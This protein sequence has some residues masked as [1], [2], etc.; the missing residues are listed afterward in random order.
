MA[1]PLNHLVDFLETVFQ[2]HR[3]PPGERGGVFHPAEKSV[4][5]L[6]LA[7]EAEPGLAEWLFRENIDAL[8]C[9]RPWQ[10]DPAALP[11]GVGVLFHHLPF[12]EALTVGFN[13]PL[14]EKLRLENLEE[15][16]HKQAPGLPPRAIGMLGEAA[17]ESLDA[18]LESLEREFG[19]FEAV[20]AG[21][22]ELIGRVA[23]VG[24]MTDALVREAADR[25][26]ALYLTG[27]VRQPARRAV[28]GTGLSVVAIGHRRSEAWGL[29]ALAVVLT[30]K[31]PDV[32][33]AVYP[34]FLTNSAETLSA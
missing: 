17:P 13:R 25:G 18:W 4:G 31:F 5:K 24:A 15:L 12:D 29:R 8:W 23:V 14:A 32:E 11:P 19:G 1:K 9:H 2:T 22:N 20:L 6:G 10:L 28:E 7:L 3:Y 27:Q 16:G 30:E 34:N 21:R 33:T 26:A